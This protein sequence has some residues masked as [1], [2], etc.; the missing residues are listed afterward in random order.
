MKRHTIAH[1]TS[2]DLETIAETGYLFGYPLLVMDAARRMHTAVPIAS[3]QQAPPNEFAHA[4]TLPGPSDKD[5]IRPHVDSLNSVAWLDL[6]H[7]PVK[8]SIPPIDRYFLMEIW[9][10][11]CDLV[12]VI[13]SRTSG[14][15]AQEFVL[16]GPHWQG[17][18]PSDI[19]MLR[20]PT[21][22][23]WINGRIQA[24]AGE[25]IETVYR[26]QKQFH[27]TTLPR[28]NAAAT[29]RKPYVVDLIGKVTTPQEYIAGLN[30]ATFYSRLSQL[31]RRN[32]LPAWDAPLIDK[33]TRIGISTRWDFLFE[34]LPPTTAHAMRA[35]VRNARLR[36]AEAERNAG[37]KMA[38]NWL[39]HAHPRRY[40]TNYL[41]RAVDL[42]LGLVSATDDVFCLQTDVDQ[43]GETLNGLN[44]YVIHFEAERL[45]PVNAHWSI[46]LYNSK[47]LLA[48]NHIRRHVIGNLDNLRIN[49]D[50]SYPI[51]VQHEWPGESKD[52][53]WLP[54]PSGDFELV[55]RLYWPKAEVLQ[56][57][58]QPPAVVRVH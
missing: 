4:R 13:S 22:T 2:Q 35:A 44:E 32:N 14:V 52:S 57:K 1:H 29:R 40:G 33:L 54:A 8:L 43:T 26:L 49:P 25:D 37:K 7:G 36:I 27:L 6:S 11:L 16:A 28:G 10:G 51:Y 30:A 53:N 31:I 50:N 19:E 42:R 17:A 15:S 23:V 18:L 38:N 21:D 5:I 9:D 3:P 24:V 34:M 20:S 46:T 12:Q 45:P 47:C 41:D 56:G 48:A 55:F 39:L 58:W